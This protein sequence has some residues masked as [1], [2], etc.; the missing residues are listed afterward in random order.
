MSHVHT[1]VIVDDERL[2]RL[3]VRQLLAPTK[4]FV[5]AAEFGDGAT[6]GAAITRHAPDVVFLDI[7]MPG[8]DGFALA[9]AVR[10]TR[11][12]IVFLTAHPQHAARAFDIEATDYLV[13]PV[14]QARFAQALQRVR[15][16]LEQSQDRLLVPSP[17]GD[18]S[19]DTSEIDWL[20]ADGAYVRV[21][22]GGRYEV[23]RES[24]VGLARRLGPGQF[25][26]VHRSAAVN[27]RRV[28][29]TRRSASGELH[30][31]L[32][33]GTRVPVSRRRRGAV[34]RRLG[35]RG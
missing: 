35:R 3:R 11:S 5:V 4:D 14:T 30:L 29:G 21:H 19:I 9:E 2:A 26:Q 15:R 16:A 10:D 33:D 32:E 28:R 24:L 27:L 12:R 22:W 34:L 17:R 23:L 7:E 1:V 25:V 13:K 31:V 18:V 8:L 6:A 20:G